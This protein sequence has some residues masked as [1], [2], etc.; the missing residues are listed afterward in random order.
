MFKR[1]KPKRYSLLALMLTMLVGCFTACSDGDDNGG[2]D[3]YNPSKSVVITDFIPKKGGVGQKLVV[4]GNNFGNDTSLVKVKIGGKPATLINVNN[5]GL[6]CFVPQGAYKGNIEV[7]VGD[8][9][10]GNQQTATAAD[11]FEYERKMVVGT[12]CGYRNERDDQGWRDGSFETV[13][14]FRNDGVLRYDPLNHNHLYV[15]YDGGVGIQLIDFETKQVT[16]PISSGAFP[17]N[18]LRSIDF[19]LDGQYMLVA[20]DRDREGNRSPSVYII[21][22]NADGTFD[23]NSDR[24]LLAAYKQCNGA[25]VHPV[26]GELYFNSYENGQVF[27]LDL[28]KYFET[29]NNGGTWNPYVIENKDAIEQ[30]FTIQ[31]NNWEFQIDIHPSGKYAYIVVINKHYILRTDYNEKTH[32]FAAPY[33]VAGRMGEDRWVDGVGTDARLSRPFQGVF[34]KNPTY[35]AEGRE[36]VYDFYFA[37]NK[38]HAVRYLTPDGIVTTYAGRGSSTA[39]ADN[40]VWGTDNGDLRQVARF[41]DPTGLAYDEGTNSFYILDTVGRKIR[42]ISLEADESEQSDDASNENVEQTTK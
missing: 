5:E 23:M 40:N 2:S 9:Q 12:L 30:L 38:N 22:R 26:N 42:T 31:D 8:E 32:K 39:A 36:D 10:Q 3:G 6:Y 28:N 34:V 25:S 14:G 13:A 33:I 37:D 1:N 29:I 18:R 41:R 17:T 11:N 35:V 20:V 19:T 21:K 4:Y 24:Q 16:T 7:T 27:R 15:C